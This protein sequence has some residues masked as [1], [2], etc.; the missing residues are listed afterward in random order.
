MRAVAVPM[1]DPQL[2]LHWIP[3]P[4]FL[5]QGFLVQCLRRSA[6]PHDGGFNGAKLLMA[7]YDEVLGAHADIEWVIGAALARAPG[8]PQKLL[9]AEAASS[10]ADA[11]APPEAE[12]PVGA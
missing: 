2:E 3:D 11:T 7:H 12:A 5:I 6:S 10:D 9:T 4:G 1:A 8:Q